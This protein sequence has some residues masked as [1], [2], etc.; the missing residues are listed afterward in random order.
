MTNP[1]IIDEM[2]PNGWWIMIIYMSGD[3]WAINTFFDTKSEE[4]STK[5]LDYVIKSHQ[6]YQLK[7]EH[8]ISSNFAIIFKHPHSY[9]QLRDLRNNT[10][11][12][13]ELP[14]GITIDTVTIL[15]ETASES[16]SGWFFSGLF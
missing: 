7:Y 15:T 1:E 2:I 16:S 8:M 4:L 3:E 13:R 14:G 9:Q 10:M 11:Y 5:W 12:N 6:I